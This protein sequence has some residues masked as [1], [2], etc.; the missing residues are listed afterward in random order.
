MSGTPLAV[1]RFT[2]YLLQF[3]LLLGVVLVQFLVINFS[4]VHRRSAPLSTG[5]HPLDPAWAGT[6]LPH[7]A[8]GAFHTGSSTSVHSTMT[9]AMGA[10]MAASFVRTSSTDA[11]LEVLTAIRDVL[12]E[13]LAEFLD[14]L[15]GERKL[16]GHL[17][18]T[19]LCFLLD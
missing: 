2:K 16:R 19:E 18:N 9:A 8:T 11:S 7:S 4:I 6:S 14:L 1:K 12:L 5:M 3:F 10:A 15:F 17:V 13:E